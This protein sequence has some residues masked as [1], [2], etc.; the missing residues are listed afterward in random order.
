MRPTTTPMRTTTTTIKE[1]TST[2]N[3]K[4]ETLGEDYKEGRK[5][6]KYHKYQEGTG[7]KDHQ[8]TGMR[9]NRYKF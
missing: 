2:T 8:Q 7:R 6:H 4:E 3:N 1:R 5:D 9:I